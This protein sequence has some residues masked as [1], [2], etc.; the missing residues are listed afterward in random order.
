MMH[1][2]LKIVTTAAFL[3]AGLVVASAGE[4]AIRIGILGD[5]AGQFKDLGGP[6]SIVAAKMA[7]EEFKNIIN[8]KPIEII[9]ADMLNKP[10]VAASIVR[11]W[12]DVDN[13]D[14][15][16]DVPLTSVAF[17]V[18]NIA[19]DKKKVVLINAAAASALTGKACSP[20][21]IHWQDNSYALSVG[22]AR[23]ILASGGKSWF[24]LTPD[25][26]FGHLMEEAAT[27][28]IKEN[29]GVV[30]GSANFP[31]GTSDYSSQ[32]VTA[33]ASKADIF[34]TSTVGGDTLNLL[35]QAS[36]FHL[37]KGK[38]RIVVFQVFLPEIHSLGLE[39]A[40]GIYVTDGFYWD[41]NEQTR[42]WSKE[43]FKRRGS[44]PS[45]SQAYVYLSVR[46]Y[47]K[48]VQESGSDNAEVVSKKMKSMPAY[49]FGDTA[50]IR[51]NGRVMYDLTLYEVKAP[52]ES[53]YPWD[54]Y[55]PLRVISAKEA[56][57]GSDSDDCPI[58]AH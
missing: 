42:A 16:A 28:T 6:G 17:A 32:L 37:V 31:L 21:T 49:N 4:K 23:A 13:V 9:S 12:F 1:S 2:N 3:L 48:A 35:K 36:E 27:G 40:R 56:L 5:Q 30:K 52:E 43:F 15:I 19:R 18:Q 34:A 38:Q 44:M 58:A 22:T 26:A 8:G 20:Y 7:A 51:G 29:G 24:F 45:K 55:R 25:Y 33:S 46:H 57:G 47:L 50:Y 10:D 39:K 41:K 53:K 11:Q 14:A 54:Y